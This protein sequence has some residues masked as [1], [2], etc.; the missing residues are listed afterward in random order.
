M[1]KRKQF[2]KVAGAICCVVAFTSALSGCKVDERYNFENI[3]NVS[4]DV[5]I[6]QNGISVP[7]VQSTAKI[8]VDSLINLSGLDT[9]AFGDYLKVYDNGDYYLGYETNYSMKEALDELNLKNLVDISSVGY[10][11]ELTYDIGSLDASNFATTRMEYEGGETIGDINI[12]TNVEPISQKSVILTQKQLSAAV[13]SAQATG[14]SQLVFPAFNIP[15]SAEKQTI[16]GFTLPSEIKSIESATLKPGAAIKME[17]SIPGCIFTEGDITPEIK[18]DLKDILVLKGGSTALDCSDLKLT[19]ANSYH[20]VKSYE[21]A[22]LNV[23]DFTADKVVTAVGKLVVT[24]LKTTLEKAKAENK[25]ICVQIK[26]TFTGIELQSAI[27]QIKRMAYEVVVPQEKISYDLPDDIGNFGTFTIIPKGEPCVEVVLDIPVIAGAEIKSD[28]GI[29]INVPEFVVFS[30]IPSE[31]TYDETTHNLT[32]NTIKKGTYKIPIERLVIT[33]KK[34]DQKYVFEGVYS[35]N[36]EIYIPESRIDLVNLINC[37][38]QKFGAKAVLPSIEAKSVKL[39]EL[40]IDVDEKAEITLVNATDIPEMVEKIGEVNLLGTKAQLAVNFTNLP[41]IGTGKYMVDLVA[42]LPKFISPSTIE[43]KGEVSSDGRFE[44]TVDINK[45][46]LSGFDLVKMRQA[47]ESIGGEILISGKVSADNP[48]VEVDNLNGKVSGKVDI[49]IA[50]ADGKINIDDIYANVNYQLDS[51]LEI[52]FFTMPEE[53]QGCTFDLPNAELSVNVVSNLAIPASAKIDFNNGMYELPLVFP[54]SQNASESKNELNKFNIDINPL[55][56]ETS[57]TIPARILLNIDPKKDCHVE[58]AADYNLDINVGFEIPLKLGEN[59][60]LS[61]SDTLD[62]Q[63]SAE[64]LRETLKKTS[65]QL[66][67]KVENTMPF[68]V[69][70][71]LELL[72]YDAQTDTY[73]VI[74]TDKPIESVLA[75]PGAT[76]D[77]TVVLDTQEGAELDKLSHIRFTIALGASGSNLTKDNYIQISG[78]GVTIPEGI[79]LN[80]KDLT[81]KDEE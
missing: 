46:D 47:G 55:I 80:L 12:N 66:F 41:D 68:K 60:D 72:G 70:V 29:V 36:G 76:N 9:T 18:V 71:K 77:F 63:D 8:S 7:L 69:G 30:H 21:I 39:D 59:F 57:E 32:L 73:T 67:G 44:R 81:N 37:S 17:V 28:K 2:A 23:S 19:P 25:D 56:K 11:T 79:S 42:S 65:A 54:Y 35:V 74:E 43:I 27:G 38:G 10:S 58:L 40:A 51:L 48:S 4:T 75:L 15:F 24:N 31:F 5:T 78:L 34:V 6:F 13:Q 14:T 49:N 26:V 1:I 52:P 3:K 20:A 33:P 22:S 64:I 16:A 50:G 61:F 45:L 62:L 53:L